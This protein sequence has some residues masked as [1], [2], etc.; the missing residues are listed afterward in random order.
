[1]TAEIA[2]KA[3]FDD[4][5]YAQ[6]WEDADV[7]V[8]AVASP[9]GATLVSV[10][11]AGDNALA[12]LLRDPGRVI[13]IDLSHAQLACLDARIAAMR[14]LDHGAF[15]ELMGASRSARRDDLFD[16]LL[17][18]LDDDGLRA[19]W[20]ARRRPVLRHGLG[21]IGKFERYFR[22]FRTW[23]LP[24][25]HGR[26]RV[27]AV[28]RPK[29]RAE[30]ERFLDEEWTNRRWRLLLSLFF[31]RTA[32]GRLG[33]D[34][35]FFDHVEGSVAQHVA[36]RLRHAAVDL[37]PSENP[38]LHWILKGHHGQALPLAWRAEHY[39]TIA[40]RLDRL[41]R[42]H[43]P[44]EALAAAGQRA[45]GFNLSDI[46]EYMD[47]PAFRRVY[48]DILRCANPG[49]RLVYWNMMAPRRVPPDLEDRIRTC[50]DA[51]QRGKAA[52]KAFFYTDFVVEEVLAP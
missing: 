48:A 11:S 19:F 18:A 23:L 32:M 14:C 24:L 35:A 7:L 25:A 6:L 47:L 41:E 29:P 27:D 34:P 16:T 40:G 42:R 43:G 44:V 38:Y 45:D 12:L 10:C 50:T 28:F 30:R 5:R 2:R 39:D 33:R 15:L 31:S 9:P 1:M 52:D 21:G 20:A 13:A 36:R 51:E 37:D 8:D 4:I 49:A 17:T 46:F 26:T 3:R 22:L